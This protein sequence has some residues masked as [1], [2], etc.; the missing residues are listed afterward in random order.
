LPAGKRW[1]RPVRSASQRRWTIWIHVLAAAAVA[2]GFARSGVVRAD[3]DDS[4]YDTASQRISAVKR[5]AMEADF[6]LE[7]QREA[8]RERI[9]Q[10][11]EARAEAERQA[12]LAARP[13]PVRL[14]EQRCTACHGAGHYME[15]SHTLPGWWFVVLRMKVLNAAELDGAEMSLLAT[16]LTQIRPA[17]GVDALTEYATLPFF[18]ALPFA[19]GWGWRRVRRLRQRD[20]R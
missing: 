20:A 14:L 8:E 6:A 7:R 3:I 12:A 5:R 9:E 15:Q 1:C 18:L 16:H 17:A 11:A 4:A 10:E 2:L 13:Y 19:A